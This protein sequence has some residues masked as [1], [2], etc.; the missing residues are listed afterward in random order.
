MMNHTQT[1]SMPF[2][3]DAEMPATWPLPVL[4]PRGSRPWAIVLSGGEGTRL[5][6]LTRILAGDERPK[7]YCRIIGGETLLQHTTRRVGRLVRPD[8]TVVVV[9]CSHA[10]FL[11]PE[12]MNNS[13][14]TQ[15]EDR[16][17]AAAIL[18]S[19]LSISAHEPAAHVAVF[20]VDH[21]F[22]S[23]ATFMRHV[24]Y[25]Y[26]AV[27][28]CPDLIV[29][30]GIVPHSPEVDYGW[31]EP[32]TSIPG[33]ACRF[34]LRVQHFWEK[35][36]QAMAAD[37]FAQGCLWNSFVLVS[38]IPTLL[39]L[40]WR[41]VPELCEAFEDA[42]IGLGEPP[43]ADTVKAV[44]TRISP[45]DFSRQVLAPSPDSLS[46]L[47]VANTGWVDIGRPERVQ[48]L[49]TRRSSQLDTVRQSA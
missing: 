19:L 15:P 7:Q 11:D 39:G 16:G 37:L 42:H 34:I 46:V 29:L 21:Y 27:R 35:P 17:T 30:L 6:P 14:L 10:Q 25:A 4:N 12:L 49:L 32:G 47:P 43:R 22:A 2:L 3:P 8:R 13:V 41:T 44:Y 18:Y 48:A 38:S 28:Q 24:D 5:R 9:M 1:G 31:I 23:D 40:M 45:V 36:P 20:P 26:R 33:V